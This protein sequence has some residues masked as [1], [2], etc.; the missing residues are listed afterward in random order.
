MAK[1]QFNEEQLKLAF[2]DA[3]LSYNKEF[4]V[5]RTSQ[6]KLVMNKLLL[7]FVGTVLKNLN[8]DYLKG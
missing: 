5:N 1:T 6:E 2:K 3:I 4:L 8:I 7:D